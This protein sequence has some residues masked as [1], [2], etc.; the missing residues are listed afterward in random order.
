MHLG[1]LTPFEIAGLPDRGRVDEELGVGAG[2]DKEREGKLVV[3]R[4]AIV[5]GQHDLLMRGALPAGPESI[6]TRDAVSAAVDLREL[7]PERS[8]RDPVPALSV[9]DARRDRDADPVV[10]EDRG[11]AAPQLA[12]CHAVP[13]RPPRNRRKPTRNA[14]LMATRK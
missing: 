6:E 9:A 5:E 11:A 2:R 12:R 13:L 10:H 4:A 3:G 7:P 1:D 14:T 8:R